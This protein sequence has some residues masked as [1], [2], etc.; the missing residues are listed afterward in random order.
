MKVTAENPDQAPW[1]RMFGLFTILGGASIL[2][3]LLGCAS[4]PEVTAYRSVK[5]RVMNEV[6]LERYREGDLKNALIN[7]YKALEHAQATDNREEAVRAHINI[8]QVLSDQD[9]LEQAKEQ[10]EA[11]LKI[12]NDMDND[13][14]L[15]SAL[16]AMG[17]YYFET[18]Q[19]DQAEELFEQ[20]L[21]LAED[22]EATEEKARTLNDLGV[23]YQELGRTDD[24]LEKLKY[25]LFLFENLEGLTAL[26]GRASA[27]NNLAAIRM[28]QGRYADAWDLYTSCLSCYQQIGDPNALVTCHTSMGG[29]LE[30]WGRKSDALLRYERAFGVAKEIPN[31]RWME[32]CLSHILRLTQELGMA[33]LHEHYSKISEQ[34]RTDFHGKPGPP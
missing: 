30:V 15:Y 27:M 4:E 2:C 16:E 19:Y 18:K 9:L 22:L 21:D 28:D 34:L 29:L 31:R 25:A 8:G 24:A 14:L 13:L 32:I 6:G 5:A 1:M 7:F 10:Y 23:V 26:Q 33:R 3:F 11:A 12:T 20:A 17:G